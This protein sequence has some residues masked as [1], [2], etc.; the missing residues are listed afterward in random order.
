MTLRRRLFLLVMSLVVP[1][2]LAS[3]S[4]A[5]VAWFGERSQAER[6]LQSTA[7]AVALMVD[8]RFAGIIKLLYALATSPYLT[9][10]NLAAF[11]QQ[12]LDAL[13]EEDIWVMLLTP[14]AQQL[15][16]TLRP[17]GTPLPAHPFPENVQNVIE[18]RQPVISNLFFGPISNQYT[19]SVHI[20][21]IRNGKVIYVLV[22]GL[23]PIVLERVLRDQLLPESWGLTIFDHRNII[24]A[25]T[26]S[27]ERYVGQ[28]VSFELNQ[29]LEV[30]DHG[31]LEHRNREGIPVLS[32]Y[33][34]SPR[35]GWGIIIGVPRTELMASFKT[36]VVL[37]LAIGIILISAGL[38][39]ARA[40]A[41]RIAR[42]ISALVEPAAALGRGEAVP[43]MHYGLREV[44]EVA[45]ALR[46]AGALL[47]QRQNERDQAEFALRQAKLVAEDSN[48]AKS[49]F[50][51]AASH[52]L[53]Q[54][55]MAA[56]LF[57]E[58]LTHRLSPNLQGTEVQHLRQ[59]LTA[60]NELLEV[61]LD[62]SRVDTGT[63]QIT[64]RD[65]S[66]KPLLTELAD[67]WTAMA[68]SRGIG[69]RA[70][71]ANA[72]V[73]SDPAL[74]KRIL[75]NLL[76]NAIKFTVT[77]RVLLGCRR[78]GREIA[79]QV[80]DTGIGI[81]A[82]KVSQVFEE[83]YQIGNPGRNRHNGLGLG[84][85]IVD[86]LARLLGHRVI[87]RSVE[88]RGTM[89]E[90]RLPLGKPEPTDTPKTALARSFASQCW[91]GSQRWQGR[92]VAID[93]DSLVLAGLA[94]LFE[95]WECSAITAASVEAAWDALCRC[96][97]PVPRL[98]LVDY[99]LAEG[100]SGLEAI[101]WLQDR[102]GWPV[103]GVVMTGE[104][105]DTLGDRCRQHGL[106]LIQKP[107]TASRLREVLAALE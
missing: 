31:L 9:D 96:P 102:L 69:F 6:T 56:N 87:V 99:R 54:P 14:S 58:T 10:G 90:I 42:P 85:S 107:V 71:P 81:S 89:F 50:L 78:C 7:R 49:R 94:A 47:Q 72:V 61:L 80:W 17:F 105:S 106:R 91:V 19:I 68:D 64:C 57:F 63:I 34:R 55:L 100:G 67:A 26:R 22:M 1:A 79:I 41:R 33:C 36:S 65:F 43:M 83:F 46:A 28:P 103:P 18:H 15:V 93:D 30:H 82:D 5:Y 11:Q 84:L 40:A 21:V 59:S 45:T 101:A 20:P 52:D 92:V 2:I 98:L 76:D 16:N 13:H 97:E 29:Q 104:S 37:V 86:R 3:A 74:V 51:A 44:D 73:H 53:R 75:R 38:L 24:A 32:A 60:M 88:G 4:A 27:P 70:V 23:L 25:R 39:V 62:L 35:F 12:A 8:H 77:G 66:L 95:V 48:K